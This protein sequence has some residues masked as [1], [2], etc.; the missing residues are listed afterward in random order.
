MNDVLPIAIVGGLAAIAALVYVTSLVRRIRSRGGVA[1]VLVGADIER[2][3]ERV[4][5]S[6]PG[7]RRAS[8]ACTVSA[9]AR[10]PRTWASS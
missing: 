5:A 2:T 8:C 9:A 10:T 4:E 3:L 1:G 6:S 7:L